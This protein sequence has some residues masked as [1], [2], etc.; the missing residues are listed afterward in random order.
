M[1]IE[2]LP[3][4]KWFDIPEYEDLYQISNHLRVKSKEIRVRNKH[5]DYIKGER[6]LKITTLSGG[7]LRVRLSKDYDQ[8]VFCVESL[9]IASSSKHSSDR[10]KIVATRESTVKSRTPKRKMKRLGEPKSRKKE[11]DISPYVSKKVYQYIPGTKKLNKI[12][13]S[14]AEAERNGFSRTEI[15]KNIRG[16]KPQ[17]RG[18]IWSFAEL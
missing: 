14:L 4:E 16:L 17:Y 2:D 5:V 7:E 13:T 18:F 1:E 11:V 6:L 15:K 8:I 9:F 3:N 10:Q 12:F